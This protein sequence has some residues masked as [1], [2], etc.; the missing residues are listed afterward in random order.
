MEKTKS[1]K[2]NRTSFVCPPE[3][4]KAAIKLADKRQAS[5]GSVV[6]SALRNLLIEEGFLDPQ[7]PGGEDAEGGVL[8]VQRAKLFGRPT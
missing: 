7:T 5:V 3:L 6:R 1:K 8:S 4:E 2:Q